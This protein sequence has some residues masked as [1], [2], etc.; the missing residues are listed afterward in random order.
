MPPPAARVLVK[1]HS[2]PATIDEL[3]FDCDTVASNL[4]GSSLVGSTVTVT[5]SDTSVL[6]G[7]MIIDPLDATAAIIDL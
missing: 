1:Q 2:H 4:P 7:T 5:F 3:K 6:T